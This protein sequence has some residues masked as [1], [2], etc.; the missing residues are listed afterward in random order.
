MRA[1][2]RRLLI[3]MPAQAGIHR[4]PEFSMPDQVEHDN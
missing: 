1:S 4:L 3:V 2:A